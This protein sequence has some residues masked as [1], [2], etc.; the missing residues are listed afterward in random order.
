MDSMKNTTNFPRVK[1]VTMSRMLNKLFDRYP[2]TA[3]QVAVIAARGL[4]NNPDV[5]KETRRQAQLFIDLGV[6][7]IVALLR[8]EEP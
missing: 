4:V 5:S 8:Q 1:E 6:D 3:A 2:L 7:G